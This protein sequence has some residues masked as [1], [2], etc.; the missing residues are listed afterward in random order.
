MIWVGRVG[1]TGWVGNKRK[2]KG[3]PRRFHD[4]GGMSGDDTQVFVYDYA[5]ARPLAS[6]IPSLIGVR[7]V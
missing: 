1:G 7:Q 3:L 4:H 2:G 6:N 5:Q